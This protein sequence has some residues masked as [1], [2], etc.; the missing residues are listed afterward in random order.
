MKRFPLMIAFAAIG[1]AVLAGVGRQLSAT[2]GG[3]YPPEG[4]HCYHNAGTC[5]YLDSM[6]YWSSCSGGE[7]LISTTEAKGI[8]SIYNPS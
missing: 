4:D 7:G 5:S 1:L 6:G 3:T 8:C 2:E